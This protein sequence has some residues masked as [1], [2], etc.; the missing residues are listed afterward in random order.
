M[1]YMFPE[2]NSNMALVDIVIAN[3]DQLDI[4]NNVSVA[5]TVNAAATD[6]NEDGMCSVIL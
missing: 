1:T 2:N 6:A 3:F 5:V 4:Q